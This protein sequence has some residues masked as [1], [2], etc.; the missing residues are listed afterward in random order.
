[1]GRTALNTQIVGMALV[2]TSAPNTLLQVRNPA[3]NAG[4]LTL[5]PSAG[6]TQPVSTHM[7]IA[8]YS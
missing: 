1:V 4:S 3:L 8:R 7:I 6:G 5:V 2:Q